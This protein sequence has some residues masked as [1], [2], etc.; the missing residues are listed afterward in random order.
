MTTPA[1]HGPLQNQAISQWRRNLVAVM[2]G[3][4]SFVVGAYAL[5]LG[6][7]GPAS[8][9]VVSALVFLGG[10]WAIFRISGH[11]API[12]QAAWSVG[13]AMMI[14]V[15]LRELVSISKGD[16]LIATAMGVFWALAL[17]WTSG[18]QLIA[19][20]ILIVLVSILVV[21]VADTSEATSI[22]LISLLIPF[23][24]LILDGIVVWLQS[25]ARNALH[26]G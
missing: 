3:S 25:R 12:L 13:V 26:T 7:G 16:R 24:I 14:S 18:L 17:V 20:F 21:S 23:A 6:L 9:L 1:G 19:R 8:V 4:L 11:R 22:L 10:A 2:A 5:I 15:L